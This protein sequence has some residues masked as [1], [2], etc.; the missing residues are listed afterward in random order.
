M[1][2]VLVIGSYL[3]RHFIKYFI[4]IQGVSTANQ[5]RARKVEPTLVAHMCHGKHGKHHFSLNSMAFALICV[6]GGTTPSMLDAPTL[7]KMPSPTSSL[8][9]L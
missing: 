9:D 7:A 5:R 3:E 1:I 4:C 8:L 2:K 6:S